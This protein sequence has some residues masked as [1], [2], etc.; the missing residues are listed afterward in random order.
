MH[1]PD[2][3]A[4]CCALEHTPVAATVI[5]L[6]VVAGSEEVEL[7]ALPEWVVFDPEVPAGRVVLVPGLVTTVPLFAGAVVF[8]VIFGI[9]VLVTTV[10]ASQIFKPH[11]PVNASISRSKSM[12]C[13]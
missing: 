3:H 6:I 2:Q 4:T 9:V 7:V 8:L 10:V 12:S 5:T 13:A 1:T 11:H